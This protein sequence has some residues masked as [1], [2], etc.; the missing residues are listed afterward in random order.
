VCCLRKISSKS[1]TWPLIDP[2]INSVVIREEL[3]INCSLDTVR[4]ALKSGGLHCRKPAKK[5]RLSPEQAAA[6]VEFCQLNLNRDWR[7]VIFSD[8]K[9]FSS[10]D[11]PLVLWRPNNTRY[12]SENV[13]QTNTS[14]RVSAGFWGWMHHAGPGEVVRV[15]PPRFNARKYMEVLEDI[16]L[17]SLNILYPEAERNGPLVFV[18]DNC[19]IH[20]ARCV[21]EWFEDND[22]V[23]QRLRWPVKSPDLNPI[24]HLWGHM[25][26]R[27]NDV[28]FH[29][30]RQRTVGAIE[31]HVRDVWESFRNGELCQ[32]MVDSMR[33]RMEECL[34]ANGYHTRY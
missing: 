7:E 1:E 24:E 3:D 2:S 22:G 15:T 27:W 11:A 21:D 14:G 10:Q 4:S 20:T 13:I 28:G 16:L 32:R 30:I 5:I 33:L 25:V 8:E 34:E 6:R 9:T 23:I 12:N 18:Q 31:T 19:C 17:P 26:T 29:G